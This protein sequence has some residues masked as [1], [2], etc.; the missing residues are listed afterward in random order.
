MNIDSYIYISV[1]MF[2]ISIYF[3]SYYLDLTKKT[4]YIAKKRNKVTAYKFL[5]LML[6]STIVTVTLYLIK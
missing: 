6:L 4:R 3:Y 2:F 5:F 1:S